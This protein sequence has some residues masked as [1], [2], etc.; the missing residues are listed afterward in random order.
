MVFNAGIS[1]LNW[2]CR[3]NH[4]GKRL[5]VAQ[6]NRDFSRKRRIA[7]FR[8]LVFPLGPAQQPALVFYFKTASR[9][10]RPRTSA[11][12]RTDAPPH[13][14]CWQCA[15]AKLR[16]GCCLIHN[17][18]R[19]KSVLIVDL[20]RVAGRRRDVAPIEGDVCPR[21]EPGVSCWT[22][23]RGCRKTRRR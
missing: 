2:D 11:I 18:R 9:R 4:V 20:D 22:N 21:R 10:P 1:R 7:K 3:D 12:I 15:G 13:P 19:R 17:Q 6:M 23:E 5:L 8:A 14:E 16:N